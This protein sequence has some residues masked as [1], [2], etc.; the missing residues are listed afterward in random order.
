MDRRSFLRNIIGTIGAV[1]IA[2]AIEPLALIPKQEFVFAGGYWM[3]LAEYQAMII[4]KKKMEAMLFW[5]I[6]FS[7]E[8][9]YENIALP[10]YEATA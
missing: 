3:P 1:I 8:K 10:V 9:S 5:G 6:P 4:F 2:P 7:K